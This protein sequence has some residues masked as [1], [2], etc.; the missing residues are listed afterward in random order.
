MVGG[1]G[2]PAYMRLLDPQAL[3]KIH[4]LELLARGV[5]EGFVAGRHRS[6]YKGFSVE[7]AEHRQYVPGDDTRDLDWR[8]YGKSDRYYI[9]QYIEETNLRVTILL[10]CSGSMKFRGTRASTANGQ[11]LSKFEYA[12]FLA[13]SMA[14]STRRCGGTSPPAAGPTTCGPCSRNCTRR[15]RAMRRPWRPSCTTWPSGRTAAE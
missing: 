9:K 12:Q 15:S 7:F 2:K 13:A 4:R 8:V 14:R 3:A 10:D 6:P 11:M 1:N 5:V